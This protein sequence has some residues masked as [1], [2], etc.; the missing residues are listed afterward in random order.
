MTHT[1]APWT[2]YDAPGAGLQIRATAGAI[3]KQVAFFAEPTFKSDAEV[4]EYTLRLQHYS[5]CPSGSQ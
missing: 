3:A 1:D 2:F 5:T 4:M